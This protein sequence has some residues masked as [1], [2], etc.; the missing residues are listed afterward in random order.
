MDIKVWYMLVSY[1]KLLH[2]GLDKMMAD[3]ATHT[4]AASLYYFCHYN[5][6]NWLSMLLL[7]LSDGILC[8]DHLV[9]TCR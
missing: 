4:V 9:Q 2:N 1:N 3:Q 6:Y 5:T 7:L 8:F